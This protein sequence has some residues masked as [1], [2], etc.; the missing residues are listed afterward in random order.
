[1]EIIYVVTAI[2]QSFGVSLGVGSSTMAIFQFFSAIADSKIE[3]GERRVM[4]VTYKILRVAMGLILAATM[5]QAV[6]LFYVIGLGTAYFTAF[7]A[8]LWLILGVLF[9]NAVGMTKHWIPSSIGPSIQAG[10]WYAL[11]LL[12]ALI[13][14]G[15]TFFSFTQFILVYLGMLLLATAIVNSMMTQM[16]R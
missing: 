8:G 1:M 6:I 4:G 11:G 16:K 7:T 3:E 13:P 5:I 15:L 12:F 10:S 14:L 9:L 2:L